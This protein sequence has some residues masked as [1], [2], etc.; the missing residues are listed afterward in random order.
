[1]RNRI[2]AAVLSSVGCLSISSVAN[3]DTITPGFS[4][5]VADEFIGL[6]GVGT[7]FHSSTGGDFGN[8]AGLAEVGRL[9]DEEVR[10]LS[11][12]NLS[13]LSTTTSAFV[14]FDIFQENG[15]FDQP[16]FDGTISIFSY[17]GDNTED[18]SD[19]QIS[20]SS[21]VGSFDTTPLTSGD[22][23]SFDVTSI[24]NSAV[25]NGE[26]SLGIRLQVAPLTQDNEAI[27]FNNFRLTTGDES[28]TAPV[29]EPS[30]ILGI[31]FMSLGFSRALKGS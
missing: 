17:M 4:F 19:F 12:Y 2:L 26:I 27:V 13:G 22:T 20:V 8:P 6:A 24:F 31:F 3:A 21:F 28:N 23:L 10:G 14:T 30:A 16:D 1:M 7:H 25:T 11:E 18:L 5:T 29:S 15:L 9:F